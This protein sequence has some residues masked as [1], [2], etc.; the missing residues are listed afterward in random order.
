MSAKP[1]WH[2]ALTARLTAG[3]AATW[4][5]VGLGCAEPIV[6]DETVAAVELTPPTAT[7]Q[8]GTTVAL[9]A[10]VRDVNGD[11]MTVASLSWSSS[12]PAIATVS[13]S[14]VVTAATPG[15]VRIAVSARG[16]SGTATVFVTARPVASLSI[17]PSGAALRVGG[18]VTLRAQLLD[19]EN[20]VLTG[21]LITW[22]STNPAVARVDAEGVVLGV[23][24]GAA[25]IVATS[26]GRSAQAAVSVSLP[27]IQSVT[28]S[29]ALD[30]LAVG[31]DRQFA[32]TLRDAEGA[33]LTGR[34]VTWASNNVGI[35]VVSATGLVTAISPGTVILSASSEGRVGSATVVV[36]ARL[37]GAVTVTPGSSTLIVGGAIAL[38]VQI[39]DDAGNVLPNRPISFGSDTPVIATVTAAGV[40]TARAPGTARITATSEGKAGVAT[41]LVIPVP[42]ASV[43]LSPASATV[44]VGSTQTLTATARAADG[45]L[46]AGRT[47][48]WLSGALGVATV[49]A[50][51]VVRAVSPGVVVILAEVEGAVASSTII[52][53]VPDVAQITITPANLAVD[54]G[55]SVQFTVVLRDATGAVLTGRSVTWTSADERIAFVSSTGLAV[56]FRTGTSIIT[57]T[58]E[59]LRASATLVVR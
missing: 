26:E 48:T 18:T 55:T 2:R 9:E 11:A 45:T 24:P 37:A 50:D 15:E 20:S 38:Q 46:L 39:T 44:L 36:A 59:G 32:V 43:Q 58:S 31:T 4:L 3:I 41:I 30:S 27:P 29:P 40:V 21:R 57:V 22:T 7:V 1:L 14:G 28:I 53:R 13:S 42:V 33:T 25:T 52:V 10:R 56:G 23:A 16:A 49:N 12:N 47:V 51:G 5:M 54:R 8:A 19:N 6:A 17:T 35:A 34:S